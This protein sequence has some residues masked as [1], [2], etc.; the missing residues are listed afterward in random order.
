MGSGDQGA[1]ERGEQLFASFPGIANKLE[2][3]EI[4]RKLFR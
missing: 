2:E 4:D 1:D 3:P